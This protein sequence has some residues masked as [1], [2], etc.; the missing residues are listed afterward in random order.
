MK[1]RLNNFFAMDALYTDT[2]VN[3]GVRMR[4]ANKIIS[5]YGNFK[6]FKDN[7][8]APIQIPLVILSSNLRAAIGLIENTIYLALNCVAMDFSDAHNNI[9]SI[10]N[11]VSSILYQSIRAVL[12]IVLSLIELPVCS[13]LTLPVRGV[14]SHKI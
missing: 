13:L 6:E 3:H 7:L 1:R 11:N 9:I 12:D 14:I 5:G 4:P 10:L 8:K 2:L